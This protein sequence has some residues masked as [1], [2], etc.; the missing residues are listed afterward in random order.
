MVVGL[1][2]RSQLE[3]FHIHLL[4]DPSHLNEVVVLK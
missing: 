3:A 4:K 1:Y 2:H